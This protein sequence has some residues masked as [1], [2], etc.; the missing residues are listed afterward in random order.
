MGY[1]KPSSYQIENAIKEA[2]RYDGILI[3]LDW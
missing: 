1:F 2:A 3:E